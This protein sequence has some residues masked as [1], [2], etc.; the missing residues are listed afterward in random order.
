MGFVG[1]EIGRLEGGEKG[2]SGLRVVVGE[3]LLIFGVDE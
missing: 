1:G 3:N 2:C